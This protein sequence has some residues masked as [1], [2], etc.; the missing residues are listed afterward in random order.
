MLVKFSEFDIETYWTG[1]YEGTTVTVDGA[2]TTEPDVAF[3]TDPLELLADKPDS[4]AARVPVESDGSGRLRFVVDRVEAGRAVLLPPADSGIDE[5]MTVPPDRLPNG[6]GEASV[7]SV[8]VE[9]GGLRGIELDTA[10][11]KERT[12]AVAE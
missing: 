11:T 9:R 7:V 12:A 3:T 6:T 1:V 8:T 4:E 2:V 5:P 10:A